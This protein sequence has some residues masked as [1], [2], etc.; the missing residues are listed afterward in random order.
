MDRFLDLVAEFES[1]LPTRFARTRVVVENRH[2]SRL[3]SR[4]LVASASDVVALARSTDESGSSLMVVVDVPQLLHCEGVDPSVATPQD[5][6]TVLERLEPAMSR[7]TGVHLWARSRRGGT[8]T[9]DMD[10]YFG[11][12]TGVKNTFLG[13]LSRLLDDGL[14]R[15]FV[16]EINYGRADVLEPMIRDLL[17]AGFRFGTDSDQ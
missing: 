15:Y 2:G 6:N 16:P 14:E 12:R 5:I 11:G 3:S 10:E 8:H 7:V 1:A 13:D 9:G 17:A 4:F